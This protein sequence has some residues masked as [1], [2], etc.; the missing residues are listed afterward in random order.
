[1]LLARLESLQSEP[2]SCKGAN[3]RNPEQGLAKTSQS[4]WRVLRVALLFPILGKFL[5]PSHRG[6]RGVIRDFSPLKPI[7]VQGKW[8]RRRSRS[9]PLEAGG[10]S[11]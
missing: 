7:L 5:Y 10:T 3:G 4:A 9:V 8:N 1:L 11:R 2:S 6:A